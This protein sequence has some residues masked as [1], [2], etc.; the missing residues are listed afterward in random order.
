MPSSPKTATVRRICAGFRYSICHYLANGYSLNTSFAESGGFHGQRRA[1]EGLETGEKLPTTNGL[2]A[3]KAWW[4]ALA[5]GGRR[6]VP[7]E[8]GAR[9]EGE[10]VVS[11]GHFLLQLKPR[12]GK[13]WICGM[14]G[15]KRRGA[16]EQS[17]TM[18]S[19]CRSGPL[20]T[21]IACNG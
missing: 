2:V 3:L 10:G 11:E 13:G 17:V 20:G 7:C 6:L 8:R 12:E 15:A 21:S 5:D 19:V 1:Q 16:K 9:G 4:L 18:A 14:G